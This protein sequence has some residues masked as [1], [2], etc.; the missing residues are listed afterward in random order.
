[1]KC[2]VNIA[3]ALRWGIAYV[4]IFSIGRGSTYMGKH[5]KCWIYADGRLTFEAAREKKVS[6]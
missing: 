3:C 6:L 5:F 4:G 1:M 2:W